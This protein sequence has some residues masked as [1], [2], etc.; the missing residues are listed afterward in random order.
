MHLHIQDAWTPLV[1]AVRYGHHSLVQAL[2]AA[3]ASIK[4]KTSERVSI[5]KIKECIALIIPIMVRVH[6]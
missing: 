3:G 1:Y 2:L 5:H 6:N 4:T